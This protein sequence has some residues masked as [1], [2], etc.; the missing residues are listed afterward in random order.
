LRTYKCS[1]CDIKFEKAKGVEPRC[2]IC[3]TVAEKP[4]EIQS[5]EAARQFNSDP[6]SDLSDL[7]DDDTFPF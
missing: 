3:G 4:H 2:P 5:R 6:W 1:K 7:V